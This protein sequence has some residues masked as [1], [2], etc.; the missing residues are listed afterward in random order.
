MTI[1]LIKMNHPHPRPGMPSTADVHPDEVA[2]MQAAGWLVDEVNPVRQEQDSI[3]EGLEGERNFSA[4]LMEL[5]VKQ[6]R[7]LAADCG[8]VLSREDNRKDEIAARIME[9]G[10]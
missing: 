8:V 10:E 3:E 1:R 2:T 9:H 7:R 5:S 6:L 4:E